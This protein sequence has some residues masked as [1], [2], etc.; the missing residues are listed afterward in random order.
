MGWVGLGRMGL[1]WA[2]LGWGGL[3]WVVWCVVRCHS[4]VPW[5]QFLNSRVH[6]VDYFRNELS[7]VINTSNAKNNGEIRKQRP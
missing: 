6:A 3:G 4:A 1:G 7:K 2:R 5:P